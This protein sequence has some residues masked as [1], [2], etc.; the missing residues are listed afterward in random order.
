MPHHVGID[1][2]TTVDLRLGS[3]CWV[4]ISTHLWFAP[5]PTSNP[6]PFSAAYLIARQT[7]PVLLE[8]S[9]VLTRLGHIQAGFR[10]GAYCHQ[11]GTPGKWSHSIKHG[12][13][14]VKLSKLGTTS[15]HYMFLYHMLLLGGTSRPSFSLSS[16]GKHQHG[17][18]SSASALTHPC[19]DLQLP[20]LVAYLLLVLPGPE[21]M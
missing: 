2:T 5:E 3:K 6:S 19:P 9:T 11:I 16:P 12:L 13:G 18:Q 15:L 21:Y 1:V 14:W 10:Y 20:L 4:G 7:H 17:P 8:Y